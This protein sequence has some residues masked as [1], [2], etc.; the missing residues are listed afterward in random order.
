MGA[1]SP[2]S[3]KQSPAFRASPP[4]PTPTRPS[5]RRAQ[6]A[7]GSGA[8]ARGDGQEATP[9]PL[10]PGQAGEMGPRPGEAPTYRGRGWGGLW[11]DLECRFREAGQGEGALSLP[12]PRFHMP[13]RR[14]PCLPASPPPPTTR[15]IYAETHRH[16]LMHAAPHTAPGRTPER[17]CP[18]PAGQLRYT[19]P[20]RPLAYAPAHPPS[21]P[22]APLPP[23]S[24]LQRLSTSAPAPD[25]PPPRALA[26]PCCSNT[27]YDKFALVVTSRMWPWGGECPAAPDRT[28]LYVN[29]GHG[30][31]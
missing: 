10:L 5:V 24:S 11:M 27:G 19:D 2:S 25:H 13:G 9:P 14:G 17:M 15:L 21:I 29:H 18:D 26:A 28:C 3:P 30:L 16:T 12:T 20:H 7:W 31:C 1:L 22:F 8:R 23:A 4:A 6:R